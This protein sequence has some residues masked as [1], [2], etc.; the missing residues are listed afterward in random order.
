MNDTILGLKYVWNTGLANFSWGAATTYDYVVKSNGTNLKDNGTS[1]PTQASAADWIVSD[2][3]QLI[4]AKTASVRLKATKVLGAAYTAGTHYCNGVALLDS[5]EL[6]ST[7]I[8]AGGT[9]S[10]W[11]G[12]TGALGAG[13]VQIPTAFTGAASGEVTYQHVHFFSSPVA[14]RVTPIRFIAIFLPLQSGADPAGHT[15][16]FEAQ[17]YYTR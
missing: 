5:S 4:G 3:L 2:D 12:S 16:Q 7:I 1:G 17:W 10:L 15:Y 13:S 14:A 8:A 6:T 11:I 9:T